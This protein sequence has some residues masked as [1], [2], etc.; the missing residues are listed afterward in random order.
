[1]EKYMKERPKK[2]IF[3][4]NEQKKIFRK[5]KSFVL[6]DLLPNP[7][8]NKIIIFGSMAKGTLGKYEA[9]HK[10]RKVSRFYSDIDILLMVE[11]NFEIHK[12]WKPHF[13]CQSYDV[14]NIIKMDK[15]IPIQY[16]VC[17]KSKYGKK[18]HQKSAEIWGVPLL[19]NKSKHKYIVLYEKL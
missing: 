10:S 18:K 4:K 1:M 3:S 6:K 2:T 9:S 8:I 14:F 12:K 11:D 7:K 5:M 17:R 15:K 16:M 19:L 13:S